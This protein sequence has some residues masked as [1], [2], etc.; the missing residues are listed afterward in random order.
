MYDT[1][2]V[3]KTAPMCNRQ[4]VDPLKFKKHF[5]W[6]PQY[7]LFTSYSLR[8]HSTSRQGTFRAYTD[9]TI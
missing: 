5:I 4:C 3:D 2:M 8:Q 6:A 7:Y 9:Q 1:Y